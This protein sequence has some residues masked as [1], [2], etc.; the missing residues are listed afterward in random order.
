MARDVN[1]FISEA[2]KEGYGIQDVV[3]F[4]SN[5]KDE[6]Y[7]SWASN[8]AA[9][10]AKPEYKS[11]AFDQD[12]RMEEE[13]NRMREE[14][15]KKLKTATTTNVLGYEV[16]S[17][18]TGPATGLGAAAAGAAAGAYGISKIKDRSIKNPQVAEIAGDA[19][20]AARI[21]PIFDLNPVTE[22]PVSKIQQLKERVEASRAAIPSKP[23]VTPATTYNQPLAQVPG[24]PPQVAPAQA[25]VAPVQPPVQAAAPVAPVAASA[26][27]VEAPA[28]PETNIATRVRRTNAQKA[29]DLEELIAKAPPGML[30][31][32][33]NPK[34]SNKLMPTDVIGQGGWHWLRS[35]EGEKTAGVWRDLFG[36]KNVGYDPVKAKYEEMMMSGGE[37]GKFPVSYSESKRQP[38]VPGHIKG[39][40]SPAA[41]LNL[42]GNA[43]G[44][45]GLAQAYQEGKKTG[46]YSDLGLGAIG[47]ILGNIAPRASL[48]FSLMSPT[49]VDPKE[50]AE[51][52]K[53]NKM[54]PTID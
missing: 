4:M 51:L 33:P 21:E 28:A 10:S 31:S 24:M 12:I 26:P 34:K 6:G 2:L 13:R 3:D 47:Q 46:D 19:A 40:V 53:R 29:K 30:P 11:G 16:P 38:Y 1:E 43:L 45:I 15:D 36:D 41:L 50:M 20:K 9:T 52:K 37:P 8:W 49:S 42:A 14:F 48:A 35:Q 25:P 17:I 39:A 44:G 18:L 23:P 27:A 7:R 5:H 54:K 32:A 22:E